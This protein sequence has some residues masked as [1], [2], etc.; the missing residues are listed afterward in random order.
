M[1]GG[2]VIVIL[3]LLTLTP[4]PTTPDLS[5]IYFMTV[6]LSVI[7]IRMLQL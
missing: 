3:Y 5:S 4:P 7:P 1:S 6:F 2:I